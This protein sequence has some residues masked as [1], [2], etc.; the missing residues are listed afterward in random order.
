MPTQA[1]F[2]VNPKLTSIAV[3]YRNAELIADQVLPRVQCHDAFRYTKF[4]IAEAFTVPDVKIGRKSEA[5]EVEF[6]GTE[7]TDSTIDYGLR[8]AVPLADLRK[9]EG[10]AFDPLGQASLNVSR[11]VALAREVRAAALVFTAGNYAA[12]NKATLSGT[13]QW[14]DYANSNPINAILTAMDAM[15][16]RPNKIV[17]GQSVWTILR[18][19]PKVVEAVKATGAGGVNAAGVVVRQ[20]VADVLE[21]QEIFVGQGWLNS[22]AKGATVT[23]G[24][25]WGKHCALMY[26]EPVSST[27]TAT[28][29]GFTAESGGGVRVRD[30]FEPQRGADGSQVVQLVD[31]VKEIMPATDLGYLFTNAVA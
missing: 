29:F 7:V 18:Q 27:E 12:A 13:S 10:T 23:L 25:V 2:P 15:V 24:R 11:L 19:H 17:M 9:S 31:T 22:A 5:N 4:A 20:A 6:S 8:D 30:W 28:T 1:P 26:T 16:M 3:S 14:S 21:V